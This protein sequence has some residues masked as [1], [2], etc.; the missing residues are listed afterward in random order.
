MNTVKAMLHSQDMD[1]YHRAQLQ[2]VKLVRKV[3]D[4]DYIVRTQDGVECHAIFNI[5]TGYYFADD[6]YRK[7]N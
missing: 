3:G 7:V 5:F 1:G 4:N 6:V 2:D